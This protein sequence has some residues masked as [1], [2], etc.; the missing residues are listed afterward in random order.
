MAN[1]K[2]AYAS[3]EVRSF[4]PE[5]RVVY[6]QVDGSK[7]FRFVGDR[8]LFSPVSERVRLDLDNVLL[9]LWRYGYATPMARHRG[10]A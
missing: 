4:L 1:G 5:F 2:R 8:S 3:A 7:Q 6:E 9:G 10:S